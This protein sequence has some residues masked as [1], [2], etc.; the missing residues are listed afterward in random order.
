MGDEKSH[1]PDTVKDMFYR[2]MIKVN[3]KLFWYENP[4]HE[5]ALLRILQLDKISLECSVTFGCAHKM[6]TKILLIVRLI[7]SRYNLQVMK[8]PRLKNFSLILK[9]H[10]W[11]ISVNTEICSRRSH[12]RKFPF[13]GQNIPFLGWSV[14]R[15]GLKKLP[16][17]FSFSTMWCRPCKTTFVMIRHIF[18]FKSTTITQIAWTGLAWQIFGSNL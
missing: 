16:G 1:N 17:S 5:G 9:R 4:A 15:K 2:A 10:A 12:H 11:K 13:L 6:T 3:M 14:S 8:S 7:P 18:Q